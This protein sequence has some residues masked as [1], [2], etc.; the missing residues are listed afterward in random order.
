MHRN[1]KINESQKLSDQQFKP[2]KPPTS[3]QIKFSLEY[4]KGKGR[5]SSAIN[6]STVTVNGLE[7]LS[8]IIICQPNLTKPILNKEDTGQAQKTNLKLMANPLMIGVVTVRQNE[9][10]PTKSCYK[11]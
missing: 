7:I 1:A 5:V 4:E 8:S 6:I 2:E 3:Y 9:R 10:P 11:G